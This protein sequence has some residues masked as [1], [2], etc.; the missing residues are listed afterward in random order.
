MW[1]QIKLNFINS[2][3]E[4]NEEKNKVKQNESESKGGPREGDIIKGVHPLE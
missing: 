2:I 1:I 4:K 3:R